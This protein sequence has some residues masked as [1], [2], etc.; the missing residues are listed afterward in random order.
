MSKFILGASGYQFDLF[1]MSF[2]KTLMIDCIAA[3]IGINELPTYHFRK[4]LMPK[5]MA[6]TSLSLLSLCASNVAIS[7]QVSIRGE[8]DHSIPPQKRACWP[9]QRSIRL[10]QKNSEIE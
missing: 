10:P 8:I 1:L 9:V 2:D 7:A 4:R 5:E 3:G 6:L